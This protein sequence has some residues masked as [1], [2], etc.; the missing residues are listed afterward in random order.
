MTAGRLPALRA[1]RHFGSLATTNPP[2]SPV[3]WATFA[4][5]QPPAAHGVFDFVDRDPGTYLPRL[6]TVE[7]HHASGSGGMVLPARAK[8]LRRGEAFWDV[9][10]ARGIATLALHVP[11]AYPPAA[12]GARS[13]AGLGA[14]DVRGTNSTYT[15]LTAGPVP[16]QPPAGGQV[17]PLQRA[18]ALWQGAVGGPSL[19]IDG[20][21]ARTEATIVVQGDKLIVGGG[22][23]PLALGVTT[24]YFDLAFRAGTITVHGRTRATLRSQAPLLLYVEPISVVP[25]AP[26]FPLSSPPEFARELE[27]DHAFAKTVGWV[28]D[29]NALVNG[30]IDQDQFLREAHATMDRRNAMTLAALRGPARLIL[31]V[32]TATD[33]IAHTCFHDAAAI[34]AA[35]E[36]MDR[37]VASVMQQLAPTDT[38]LVM[39]DHGFAEF[40]RGMDLNR[41]LVKNGYMHLRGARPREFFQDVQWDKTRAYALGTGNI[42][43]NRRGRE[44]EGVVGDGA[45]VAAEIAAK[46][47]GVQ[48]GA[49]RPVREVFIMTGQGAPDLRVALRAGYRTSWEMSLGGVG[50]RVFMDNDRRWS[51]DHASAHP[52]D[53][54]GI[55]VS[56]R[57]IAKA[58]PRIEDLAATACAFFGSDCQGAGENLL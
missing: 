9:L 28:H 50:E 48:D 13:M 55:L 4:T 22:E 56:N 47:R 20:K 17:A 46:L 57:A 45:P 27:R 38:L 1:L 44:A 42:Y 39:S 12:S 23:Y 31:S 40:R 58:E 43:L 33:R 49:T 10:A 19:R 29:T 6:A 32:F 26:Y 37:V 5:G 36:H 2:Q 8:N 14:P 16:P 3:A 30:A 15:V 21:L 53:V 52:D 24:P 35:Y 25:H 54:P 11:Y 41:W 51:G 18:G 34:D 7:L